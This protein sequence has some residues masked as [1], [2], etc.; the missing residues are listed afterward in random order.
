MQQYSQEHL[1]ELS[2]ELMSEYVH[3]TIIPQMV[4]QHMLDH[5]APAQDERLQ[6]VDNN[7]P[8][9]STTEDERVSTEDYNRLVREAILKRYGLTCICPST[10]HG[11]M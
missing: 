3:D 6:I 10:I 8:G 4:Q 1:A 11:W 2:I 5:S 7:Q 9:N